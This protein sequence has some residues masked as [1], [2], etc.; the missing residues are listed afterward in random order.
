M[1]NK[2][3]IINIEKEEIKLMNRL[4]EIENE[5]KKIRENKK[6]LLEK[7]KGE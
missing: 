1:D 7:V 2:E 4:K 3:L 5:L 6:A